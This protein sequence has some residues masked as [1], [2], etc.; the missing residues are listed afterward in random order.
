[1]LEFGFFSFSSPAPR[2]ILVFF[3]GH[4]VISNTSKVKNCIMLSAAVVIS[5]LKV[6]YTQSFSIK[7]FLVFVRL[8]WIKI[9]N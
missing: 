3:G 9:S 6:K 8:F 2:S 1:M 4:H 5:T 7:L